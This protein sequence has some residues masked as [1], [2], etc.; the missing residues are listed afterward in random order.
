MAS[1]KNEEMLDEL[2]VECMD[3]Q[4]AIAEETNRSKQKS[5]ILKSID[6]IC[7]T[8]KFQSIP[9]FQEGLDWFNVSKPLTWKEHLTG[10]LVLIDFWTYC[11]INCL[12]VLPQ[13]HRLEKKFTQ[14]D[15]LV[16]IGCH[17]AKFTNEKS[18]ENVNA[19][20]QRH[21]I[22]HP[23][24]ND[25]NNAMWSTLNIQC[26][27]T[28]LLMSPTGV[29]IY[30]VM[31]EGHYDE[32]ELVVG[33]CIEY[34]KE[35]QLLMPKPLPI[36]P[37]AAPSSQFELK[38]PGK[39]QCSNY[40]SADSTTESLFALSDS[41]NHRIII[42]NSSGSVVHKIGQ[43]GVA[44]YKD[45]T[46]DEAKFNCPQGVAW[47]D[48]KTLFVADTENHVIRMV[49]LE[50]RKV[51]TIIGSGAQGTDVNGG[52][53]PLQQAISSP[54]DI[55]VYKTKNMDMSFHE[56]DSQVPQ[57]VVLVIAMAG[58]HQVWAYFFE[59]TIWWR[60]QVQNAN[61]VVPIAGNG[62]ER[63]RNNDYPKQASFAQ[64]SGLC[65]VRG[66]DEV[67]I[68]DSESSSIRKMSLV[69]GKVSPVVGGANNLMNL[70]AYGDVDGEKYQARLQ[71]PLGLAHHPTSSSIVFVADTFNNKIKRINIQS[72]HIQTMAITD[73]IGG[74]LTFN[75]PSGLCTTPDGSHLIVLNTNSHELIR[76]NLSTLVASKYQLKWPSEKINHVTGPPANVTMVLV[77][78][79][80]HFQKGVGRFEL[81]I[82][83]NLHEGVKLTPD[84][85]QKIQSYLTRGWKFD[86]FDTQKLLNEGRSSISVKIPPGTS[87]GEVTIHF[88]LLLCDEKDSSCFR[89]EF[90][91]KVDVKFINGSMPD[92][93]I[94]IGVTKSEILI[95]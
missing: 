37:S 46:F 88:I 14:E 1:I 4:V 9:D 65:L 47:L 34:F 21:D 25:L 77:P 48:Q 93:T 45:G 15:G 10:S 95:R 13:L 17:S 28:L 49:M 6:I 7:S 8:N 86:H 42:F 31:G 20:I 61:T 55:V 66:T 79:G 57:K 56:D 91:V 69:S 78:N 29:P 92:A 90:G 82:A 5:L 18:S 22:Q 60:Y 76:I 44:G 72:N 26:W 12:H 16:I 58:T 53:S 62:E 54:W 51:Q 75:E 68:A 2:A 70:F 24:V 81:P 67:F 94:Y 71:H 64:P 63:N 23:V 41:G 27:P 52:N 11:C 43:F 89:K 3:L 73:E 84:A 87:E 38:F 85:P 36:K 50:Q 33:T 40:D 30:L 32:I 83:L 74:L 19:A 35:K 39:I 80:R 59:E